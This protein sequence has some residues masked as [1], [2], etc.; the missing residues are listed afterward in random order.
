MQY[1]FLVRISI[2]DEKIKL[3]V[4]ANSISRRMKNISSA[5][6]SRVLRA[7]RHVLRPL[8]LTADLSWCMSD[9]K[10]SWHSVKIWW[11]TFTWCRLIY[12][13]RLYFLYHQHIN[14][15]L[16]VYVVKNRVV[17]ACYC[18]CCEEWIVIACYCLI[19]LCRVNG[20]SMLLFMLWGVNGYSMLLFNYVV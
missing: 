1:V 8:S 20:Y 14:L 13:L 11:I 18:L 4:K 7:M 10:A 6:K 19:M 3:V 15:Y 5:P 12:Y 16:S 17:T 2:R 9:V